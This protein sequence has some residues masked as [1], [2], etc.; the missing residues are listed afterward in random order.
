MNSK[1]EPPLVSVVTP[2]Y[3]GQ[4][5]LHECIESILAQTYTHWDYTIVNNC[6]TDRTLEIVLEYAA[7]DCR[8]RVENN[9][10]FVPIVKNYNNAFRQISPASK[11]CKV[12]GA[13]DWLFPECLEKMVRLAEEHPSV[14]VVQAYRLIGTKVCGDGLP[15]PSTVIRGRDACRMWLQSETLS[16]FGSS[17]TLMYRS[18]M[19]RSRYSFFKESN[20]HSDTEVCLEFLEDHD[21]GFVHQVLSFQRA[22]DD[23]NTSYTQTFGT[24]LPGRLY[25]LIA[26][27][28]KF[29]AKEE[30]GRS[31]S[32]QFAAYYDYLG[33]Q[34]F[35]KRG[36]EFWRFHEREL[37]LLGYPMSKARVA[38]HAF[39]YILILIMSPMRILA[40][41]TNRN[42]I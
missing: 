6:S 12:V 18:D 19:V 35:K 20:L 8:I 33:W 34:V 27:G 26:Y 5:H 13:D 1:E 31:I 16:I 7:K 40:R 23:G 41:L 42:A 10:N 28:P 32:K 14:I 2:V 29:L 11:Y 15:Y 39:Q 38:L 36:R 17:T 21:Y 37:A 4:S 9:K 30:S 3:N 22:R 25:H 24:M